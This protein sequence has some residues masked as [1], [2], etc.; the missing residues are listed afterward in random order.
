MWEVSPAKP[1]HLFIMCVL[2]LYKCSGMS[3]LQDNVFDQTQ[4]KHSLCAVIFIHRGL[5]QIIAKL[6]SI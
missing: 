3:E 6:R 4:K 1:S 2:K 5:F